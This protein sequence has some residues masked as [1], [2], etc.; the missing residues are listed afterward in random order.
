MDLSAFFAELNEEFD[1]LRLEHGGGTIYLPDTPVDAGYVAMEHFPDDLDDLNA[2]DVLKPIAGIESLITFE[3]DEGTGSTFGLSLD[4][5][6]AGKR[7]F[8]TVPPDEAVDQAWEAFA[9]IENAEAV[10]I[11]DA[12]YFDLMW[13]NGESYGIELFS[14]L[15][16]AIKSSK[17]GKETVRAGFHLYLD[18]DE[19]RAPGAWTTAAEHLPEWMRTNHRLASAADALAGDDSEENRDRFI[20]AYIDVTFGV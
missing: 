16:T 17:L 8:V 19:T 6:P 3:W 20:E 12:L 7:T 14:S 9:A 4:L 2:Y 10:E 11:L 18:W 13:D 1:E 15:P 5:M